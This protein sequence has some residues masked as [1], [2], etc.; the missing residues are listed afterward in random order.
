MA[1][2]QVKVEEQRKKFIIAC[3]DNYLNFTRLCQDFG[4]S[5][6]TGY[7]WLER[8]EDEGVDG[9][10]DRS[11][12]PYSHPNIINDQIEKEI[13]EMKYKFPHLGPKKIYAKLFDLNPTINWPCPSTIGNIFE[14]NGLI[15]RRKLR[16]RLAANTPSAFNGINPNDVWCMDFK[17]TLR[18]V[19][20][21]GYDP[22]TLSDSGSRFL[23]KCQILISNNFKNVWSVLDIAFREYG[24]PKHI[25]SDNGPP[26]ATMGAGRLSRISI[27]L[28]KAGV[29]P[30][31]ITPGKPQQNGRHE[32]MHGT[33]ESVL[34][35]PA[36]NSCSE[37]KV[38]LKEFQ[39]YYNYDR[40]HEALD[41]KS[42][43][44]IFIPSANQWNGKFQ[45]PEY[46]SEYDIRKV[47]KCGTIN[48][49]GER[50]FIGEAFY[51]EHIGLLEMDD[52]LRVYYGPI[53]LGIVNEKNKIE[54]KKI[55]G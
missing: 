24:L 45:T 54:F 21:K 9:L 29:K 48:L 30:I 2:K 32:R 42:P 22:F 44:S 1:W 35:K 31:W 27:N 49:K 55:K 47:Q 14:R 16:K 19:D 28:I 46:S 43:G 34:G 38:K 50:I 51:Q 20:N 6:P 36:A 33:M 13:L 3:N 5:R 17:G 41:Q 8:Y 26:F 18:T 11:R 53:F 52:G 7:K 37:L 39:Y 23:I 4:I 12:A 25:L 40:P 15:V 10:S